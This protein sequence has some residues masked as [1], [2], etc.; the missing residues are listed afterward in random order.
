MGGSSHVVSKCQLLGSQI[1]HL[2]YTGDWISRNFLRIATLPRAG[3]GGSLAGRV[4]V[5]TEVGPVGRC[6]PAGQVGS[7]LNREGSRDRQRILQAPW[8]LGGA[9]NRGWEWAQFLGPGSASQAVSLCSSHRPG[10]SG[11]TTP[12]RVSDLC[13][14]GKEWSR[15]GVWDRVGQ[16]LE[17]T[18]VR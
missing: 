18:V 16:W 8:F 5:L 7:L 13:P 3:V 11:C 2:G 12:D 6:G 1:C 9:G 10:P 15:S 14:L 4:L 17:S